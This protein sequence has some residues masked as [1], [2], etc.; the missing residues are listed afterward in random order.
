[1]I[2]LVDVWKG[3]K[4]AK[5]VESGWGKDP[6]HGQ[7]KTSAAEANGIIRKLIKDKY[8]REEMVVAKER[9]AIAYIKSGE[10]AGAL[11]GGFAK[12]VHMVD[13]GSISS[14]GAGLGDMEVG[15]AGD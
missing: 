13:T 1:M 9:R 14:G 11:V 7:W 4:S 12:V 8:L 3:G 15:A 5:T 10:K 2:Q 6:L